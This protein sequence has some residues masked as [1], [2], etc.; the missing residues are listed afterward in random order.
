MI[1]NTKKLTQLSASLLQLQNH[2]TLRIAL[3][4]S[5]PKILKT[6]L[7]PIP[8]RPIVSSNSTATYHTSNYLDKELPCILNI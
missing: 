6:L 4:Y 1:P 3:F 7:Q 8:G 2:E 5:I